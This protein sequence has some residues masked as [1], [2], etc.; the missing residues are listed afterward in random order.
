MRL[1]WLMLAGV[2]TLSVAA[3]AQSDIRSEINR[4]FGA[5]TRLWNSTSALP[6]GA[7]VAPV[8]GQAGTF[9]VTIPE[10]ALAAGDGDVVM[11]PVVI[12]VSPAANNRFAFQARLPDTAMLRD[13]RGA[14]F[15]RLTAQ[16]RSLSG[17]WD[18]ALDTF[19]S[20]NAQ[21]D[22]VKLTN[23]A[24]G[25]TTDVGRIT[26][27]NATRATGNGLYG[28]TLKVDADAIRVVQTGLKPSE[29]RIAQASVDVTGDRL[30]LADLRAAERRM[31]ERAHSAGGDPNRV[32]GIDLRPLLD[33][34]GEAKGTV[35]LRNLAMTSADQQGDGMLE[36]L[37][38][39]FSSPDVS[40]PRS[41]LA[42]NVDY[43][44]LVATSPQAPSEVVP[45]TGKIV[46]TIRNAPLENLIRDALA[47]QGQPEELQKRLIRT[48]QQA[49]SDV[50]IDTV[51][52][53]GPAI[54]ANASGTLKPT[55]KTK[56]GVVGDLRIRAEGLEGAAKQLAARDT[57]RFAGVVIMLNV[58]AAM[59][60]RTGP[61]Y[62]YDIAFQDSG[63]VVVNGR[64]FGGMI[65]R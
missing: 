65:G 19:A 34:I 5:A 32:V 50:V 54:T 24:Q 30:R 11:G 12:R 13:G 40:K 38:A 14:P 18:P 42:L 43:D 37:D 10:L 51:D 63:K 53:R 49:G 58:L 35:S 64:D 22:G 1:P 60:D 36:R 25:V 27:R 56:S 4:A 26:L 44:G 21:L 20:V 48:L 46:T 55:E 17:E 8:A 33:A 16:G 39:H 31:A 52:L 57:R 45:R 62:R 7:T 28:L 47:A 6:P 23:F 15:G 9:D 41:T 3:Q 29:T 59:A 61:T 2:L